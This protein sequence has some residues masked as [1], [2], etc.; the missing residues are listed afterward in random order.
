M[1]D[2]SLAGSEDGCARL[3][4]ADSGELLVK[5]ENVGAAI[6]DVAFH[7]F[8]NIFAVC[9]LSAQQPVLLYCHKGGCEN[10]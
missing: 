2:R 9:C 8:D 5:Y 3:W 4:G 7:P 10:F 6:T 1:D